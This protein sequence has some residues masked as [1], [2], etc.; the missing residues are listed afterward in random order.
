MYNI[1]RILKNYLLS[2]LGNFLKKQKTP[3]FYVAIILCILFSL[4]V[5]CIFTFNAIS[6]IQIY[7]EQDI[8]NPELLSMFSTTTLAL[9]MLLFVTIM[10]SVSPSKSSDTEFLMSMPISKMQIVI[11]RG[12]YN[13]LFDFVIFTSI[14]LP[15]YIVFY[16]LVPGASI[17]IVLRG[18]VFLLIL[19]L[20]SNAVATF[21]GIFCD[22]LSRLFK[23]YTIIQTVI[24]ILL[25]G[26]YLVLNY[27]LQN[28]LM[29][30]TGS[31]K[32][33]IDS[34]FVVKFVLYY[35]LYG[36]LNNLAIILLFAIIIYAL[37]LLY[38]NAQFG[39]LKKEYKNDNVELKYRSWSPLKALTIKEIKQ[40]FNMPIYLIN[41][42]I[43]LVLYVGL[44]VAASVLGKDVALSFTE[45]LPSELSANFDI[46]VLMIFSL[47]ISGFAITGSSISLEGKHFW[48]VRTTPVSNKVL[49]GS[50]ILTNLIIS[51]VS[52]VIGF[53]FIVSFVSIENCWWFLVVPFAA[54]AMAS[55]LGLVINLNFP[56][57]E[58]DKEEAVVKSSMSSMISLFLP[59]ILTIVPFALFMSN[60]NAYLTPTGFVLVLIGYFVGLIILCI[61][62][63]KKRGN[64]CLYDAANK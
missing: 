17:L 51:T 32:D 25:I 20:I 29:N 48:L 16:V 15:S 56:K 52:I 26:L 59:V 3:K 36:N 61:I 37:S 46:L 33:I 31:A 42:I 10:R 43:S 24:S 12:I 11:A 60:L 4:L 62:W 55:T 57:L 7:L 19:P 47:L 63:L 28:Y 54:S 34:I 40:Y 1:F 44:A 23:F 53:L 30:A 35:V 9:M 39:K 8:D 21:I 22:K 6:S 14:I 45:L 27:S 38:S 58:W 2:F 64:D 13:Y 41:T 5:I 18:L 50:K 49:F